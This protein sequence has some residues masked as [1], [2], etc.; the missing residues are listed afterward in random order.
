[1]AAYAQNQ[2]YGDDIAHGYHKSTLRKDEVRLPEFPQTIH[3]CIMVSKAYVFHKED[4]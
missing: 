2:G 3:S 1:M 4:L